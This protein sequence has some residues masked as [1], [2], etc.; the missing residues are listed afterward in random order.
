MKKKLIEIDEFDVGP[1]NVMNYGHSFGHAIETLTGYDHC[2]HGDGVA[3]GMVLATKLSE[4]M[5]MVSGDDTSR[6]IKLL[7]AGSLPVSLPDLDSDQIIN[8]MLKDK[9]VK[10]RKIQLVLLKKMGEAYLTSDYPEKKL[11]QLLGGK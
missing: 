8:V 11:N 4:L 6:I 3:I 2:S 5:G 10:D 1:R 9:K 7:E